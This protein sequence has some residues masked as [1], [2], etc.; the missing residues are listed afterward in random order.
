LSNSN[1]DGRFRIADDWRSRGGAF[2]RFASFALLFVAANLALN[3]LLT[4]AQQHVKSLE[5]HM[6]LAMTSLGISVLVLTVVMARVSRRRFSTYGYA[7]PH[8]WRNFGIG[9]GCGIS[10]LAA[11][12]LAINWLGFLTWGPPAFN[13]S[14]LWS[15]VIYAAFFLTVGF[16]EESLFRGYPLVELSHA[17]S[18]WGAAILMG[19]VFGAVHWLKG[20]GE[21]FIGG[22]QAVAAAVAFAFSFRMTGSLWLAIGC[23]SGWNYAQSFVFGVPNSAIV[24]SSHVLHPT[25]HGPVWITGGAV[26]PEGSALSIFMPMIVAFVSWNLGRQG[27]T[28]GNRTSGAV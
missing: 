23:H 18:F 17:I 10:L 6:Q 15:G 3:Y 21:N 26:G 2:L 12:L 1:D 22:L 8:K 14:L 4:S 28:G 25:F 11:Q 27:V 9:I 5:G 20:G 7:G 19:I 16:T 13:P 24:F